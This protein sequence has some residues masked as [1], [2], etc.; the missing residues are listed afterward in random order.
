MIPYKKLIKELRDGIDLEETLDEI[1]PAIDDAEQAMNQAA[2]MLEASTKALLDIATCNVPN[3]SRGATVSMEVFGPFAQKR[4][5]GI[6]KVFFPSWNI[7]P[8]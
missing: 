4:A 2:D 3:I 5:Q 8:K 1:D 6:L 7:K